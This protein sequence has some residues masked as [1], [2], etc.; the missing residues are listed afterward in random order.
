FIADNQGDWLPASKILHVTEGAFFG[1]RAVDSATV[2]NLPVKQPVVWLPQDEIGNSPSTPSWLADGPY[3]GQMIHGEV[4]HGGVKRVFVEK[5]KGEYQGVVFRFIQG[6]EAGVN[7]LVWGPDTALYIGGIGSTGNWQHS[8]TQWYGLQR[9]KYNGQPT[10]EMLAVRAKSNGMEI[11]LTEP[12]A[13]GLG[14]DP[15]EYDIQQWYYLPTHDYGGPKLDEKKL[16]ILSVNISEDR[17]K[18]FLELA[19]ME[20]GHVVYIH[21]PTYWT[22]ARTH[23]LWSTEAWYTLNQIPDNAP[24]FERPA[25]PP[26]APNTLT[27]AE[28]AAG[29]RLLFDGQSTQG[30][31]SYNQSGVAA[32]WTVQ[33]GAL[34]MQ[35]VEGSGG[36]LVTNETY[37]DFDLQLEWKIGP[38]GN[39]GVIF[40]V[41]ERE[42]LS[43]TYLSGP[44]IQ[45]L[46]NTCH[47]DGAYETHRAGGL[48]DLVAASPNTVRPSGQWNQARIIIQAGRLEVWLNGRRVVEAPL[49]GNEWAALVGNSKFA[50]WA[51][52][53]KAT[54]GRI[55]L[56]DHGDRVW[57][58]NIKIRKL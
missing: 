47:P 6:L 39:S 17:K 28:R 31:H 55:A 23:E 22:S 4:T 1:S 50:E 20:P 9:L 18:I 36:D 13:E 45:V 7:R 44:E 3:A 56:Q 41:D 48:F 30:W 26:P 21:L 46:D 16:D 12:L 37:G 40:H 33:D 5:V 10:F 42:D 29:W 54:E 24:G 19:G 25:P 32:N 58:R 34:A 51:D 15:A 53:G 35:P 2:A 49:T 14:G 8:G 43:Q 52:F 38:C 11:E 57:F 27:E